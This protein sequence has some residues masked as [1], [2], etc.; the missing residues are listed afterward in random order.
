MMPTVMTATMNDN[1]DSHHGVAEVYYDVKP[2]NVYTFNNLNG[3]RTSGHDMTA[4]R[5]RVD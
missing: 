3:T 2:F 5:L 4:Q 1:A